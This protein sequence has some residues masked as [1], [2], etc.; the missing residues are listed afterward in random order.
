MLFQFLMLDFEH[1]SKLNAL[2]S[3]IWLCSGLAW[4]DG[5][6]FFQFLVLGDV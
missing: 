5:R 2:A 4:P 1:E 6:S 3:S